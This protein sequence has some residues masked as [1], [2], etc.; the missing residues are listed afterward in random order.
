MQLSQYVNTIVSDGIRYK[1]Y[2]LKTVHQSSMG[3]DLGEIKY[4]AVLV[5]LNNVDTE[6]IYIKRVQ[7]SV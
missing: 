1:P 4:E 6:E 7:E 5:V 2:L 3:E